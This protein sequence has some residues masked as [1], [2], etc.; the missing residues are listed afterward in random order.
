MIIT[1]IDG[2]RAGQ[3]S[4]RFLNVSIPM[5]IRVL[6]AD[7]EE[8]VRTGIKLILRHAHGVEVIAEAAD[9]AQ[10][11]AMIGLHAVDVALMDIRML[12]IDGLAATEQIG[13]A[14]PTVR[15]VML[16][17]FG[18]E[19]NVERALRAGAAGFVL[20]DIAPAA[21]IQTVRV[22]ATGQEVLAPGIAR[23]LVARNSSGE[24]GRSDTART[25]ISELTDRERM[26]AVEVG[27]GLPNSA[28]AQRLHLSEGTVKTHISRILAKLR[29]DSRVQIAILARD[30]GI[31]PDRPT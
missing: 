6:L 17:T 29:C 11:V 2:S 26:V 5:P 20:K 23:R 25:R 9:G 15:V 22:A 19:A 10:A 4:L 27:S 31:L 7:D 8:L 14:A 28:I 18:D 30:A 12:R 21:L 24:N 3:S 1:P 16:T 13:Q